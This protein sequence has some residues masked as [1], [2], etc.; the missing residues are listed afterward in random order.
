MMIQS[1]VVYGH[2]RRTGKAQFIFTMENCTQQAALE[3]A[4]K[5]YRGCGRKI[6]EMYTMEQ[7]FAKPLHEQ[8]VNCED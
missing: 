5:A 7:A 2:C 1:W 3:K 4:K 8:E 6:Q